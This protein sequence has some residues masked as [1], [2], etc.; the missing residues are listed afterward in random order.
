[1][2]L[3]R[4]D[5]LTSALRRKARCEG[6]GKGVSWYVTAETFCGNMDT[7]AV[8]VIVFVARQIIP[9]RV[10]VTRYLLLIPRSTISSQCVFDRRKGTTRMLAYRMDLSL[11]A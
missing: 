7:T 6:L 8:V 10:L 3:G 4:G 11:S 5:L 1:M 9:V 2:F